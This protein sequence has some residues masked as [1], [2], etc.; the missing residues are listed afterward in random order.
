MAVTFSQ[1]ETEAL[2][3][4][5]PR[6]Q[7]PDWQGIRAEYFK[8]WADFPLIAQPF[9]ITLTD[10]QLDALGHLLVAM[11]LIDSAIDRQPNQQTRRQICQLILR[12]MKFQADSFPLTLH[13]ETDR[14]SELRA[15][16]QARNLGRPFL[17][18]ASRVF[19]ASEGKR[20]SVRIS[21]M[22]KH[23]IDEGQAAA[24]MTFFVIGANTNDRFNMFSQRVM[25]VGPIVD[26]LL[27]AQEDFEHG[28]LNFSP[29]RWFRWRLKAAI[30]RQLPG[31]ILGFPDRHL[32][33]RYC[34]SYTT[35]KP[36]P[37]NRSQPPHS[38]VAA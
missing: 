21:E 12:W 11:D 6:I 7:P 36:V 3:V 20:N 15:F 8:V 34:L 35:N 10:S 32:L 4:P 28:L 9:G 30:A 22:I 2:L 27:D 17:A 33:W 23:L 5:L 1:L 25:R 19:I 26:T 29:N 16:L 31:L 14:L 18:A 37:L 13:L 24:E 38:T